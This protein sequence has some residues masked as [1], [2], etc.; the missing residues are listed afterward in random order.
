MFRQIRQLIDKEKDYKN[1]KYLI[2]DNVDKLSK[3]DLS[4]LFVSYGKKY[5]RFEKLQLIRHIYWLKWFCQ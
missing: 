4:I 1:V 2:I 3:K 5:W